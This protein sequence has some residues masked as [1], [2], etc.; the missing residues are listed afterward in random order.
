MLTDANNYKVILEAYRSRIVASAMLISNYLNQSISSSIVEEKV[1]Q[2]V[3]FEIELAK[4]SSIL[5]KNV[6]DNWKILKI[7]F[8][9][10]HFMILCYLANG[11]TKLC[12][13]LPKIDNVYLY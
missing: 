11:Y 2:I 7:I 4:V 9:M 3:N 13:K 10:N 12:K 8:L 6:H 5:Y 1:S